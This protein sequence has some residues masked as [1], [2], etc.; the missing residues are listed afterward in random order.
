V[1]KLDIDTDYLVRVL[2]E[3]LEI[4]SPSGY[5]DTIVRYVVDQLTQ[6]GIGHEITRRGAIRANLPG[7]RKSPDRALVAHLD[8]LGAMVTR[9]QPNGRLS[10][11]PIGTWSSRFAEGARV[12]ILTDDQTYRGTI[13]P[14][15]SSGHT[16]GDEIDTQPVSWDHVEVRVDAR[17][18]NEGDLIALGFHVGDYV[19]VD[20]Q[21]EITEHDYIVS[22]HLDDKAGVATLLAAARA[23]KKADIELPVDCHLLFTIFEEVGSGASAVLHQDVAEMVS[24]DNSTPAPGQNSTEYEPAISMMDSS[25]PFDYHLTHKLIDL[26]A[27]HAVPL[28]RGVFR[29]YRSDAATA[30]EAGSDI[31]TAL[32]CFGVDSSHGWERTHLDGLRYLGTLLCLYMQSPAVVERDSMELGPIKGFTEQPVAEQLIQ[33]QPI[34]HDRLEQ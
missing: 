22:R 23:I 25:G 10:V 11:A 20:P 1:K 33:T 7:R 16:F 4:P 15:K 28:K 18:A 13:L 19:A 21:P 17:A 14:L 2:L 9:L 34:E 5:T 27:H 12:S 24:I 8:T 6:L 29:Y 31:R 30:V 3:L 32:L 26:A